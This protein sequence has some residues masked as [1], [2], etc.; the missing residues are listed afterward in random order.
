MKRFFAC[1]ISTAVLTA[2][3]FAGCGKRPDEPEPPAAT[4][5]PDYAHIP[6]ST[7]APTAEPTAVPT[8]TAAPTAVPTA[9]PTPLPEHSALYCGHSV[10]DVILYFNEVCLDSEYVNS[11][12]PSFVQKWVSPISYMV[13]GAYTQEDYDALTALVTQLNGIYG[14]PGMQEC[15][16]ESVSNLD[17]YFCTEQ[18][19]KDRMGYDDNLDGAVTFWY[20]GMNQIYDA[21]ICIRTDIDQTIRTSVILE[22]I[23]NG[24]GPIQDTT[25]RPDSIIYQHGSDVLALSDMDWL[26]LKLLYHPDMRCGL[27]PAQAESVLRALYY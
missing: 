11:G 19:L 26:L 16:D 17:I 23:Y 9:T 1:I 14:F 27:D 6:T 10:E 18:E 2:S 12:D 22:E 4:A 5:A 24:L 20:D 3:L 7:V 15:F 8:A 25:L 21:I 13:H